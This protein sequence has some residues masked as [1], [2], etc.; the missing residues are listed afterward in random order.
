MRSA[1]SR[2]G[3]LAAPVVLGALAAC[4]TATMSSPPPPAQVAVTITSPQPGAELVAAA[5]PTIAVTGTV[6]ATGPVGALEAWVNGVRVD[7]QDGAFTASVAPEVGINHIK[8][9]AGDGTGDLVARELDVM[10]APAYLPPPAGQTGFDVPGALELRLGQHFFDA[11]LLGSAL[12]RSTDPIVARDLA[13]VLEL[14]LWNVNLAGL[15]PPGGVHLGSGDTT[16]DLTIPSVA[17]SSIV[18]DA[19]IVD[20]PSAIDLK[21]DLAGVFL[22]MHGTA[23]LAGRTLAI[24]GGVT[25]DLHASA[26]LTLGLAP[27]RSITVGVTGVT[28][29]IGP[30]TPGFQGANADELDALLTLGS[31]TFRTLIEG[32]LANQLIP[33]F[34]GRLPPLLETLLGTADKLLDNLQFPLDTGLGHPVT[35][36][37]GGQIGAL[38]VAAGATSG[39]VT[40]RQ[41]LTIATDGAPLHAGSLGAPRVDAS[42]ADPVLDTSGVHLTVRQDFLNALLHALWNAGM[43]DGR[44]TAGLSADVTARLPPIV[45]PTPAASPCKIDGKRCDVLLELGQVELQIPG[46]SQSFGVSASAGARIEIH[47]GTVSFLIQKTPDVRVWDTS[48]MPGTLMTS[49]VQALITTLVWPKLFGALGDKLTFS[50]PLPDLASLGLGDLAPGLATAQLALPLRDRPDV[51]DGVLVLG[52]DLEL[53]TPR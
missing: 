46:F 34:T 45:R 12:D 40:L 47:G 23:T 52:A 11:R 26:R 30:L 32:L 17:P 36:T 48:A 21:I 15:L 37:L 22:A 44:I 5:H 35:V 27:D 14:I 16:I 38:D 25:A 9:E 2:L 31:S 18:A 43:L 49:T 51:D 41:D 7:V 42:G 24:D 20:S 3:A 29:S 19:R 8:V 39:H 13:S 1:C 10:W 4:G 28:A 53:S 50:L 33:T 6:T